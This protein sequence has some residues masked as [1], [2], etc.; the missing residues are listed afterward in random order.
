MRATQMLRDQHRAIG[1]LFDRVLREV[2]P[3]ERSR[4]IA[5]L[6][7]ELIAHMASEETVF[8]PAVEGMVDEAHLEAA[9][10]AH[11]EV[12]LQLR[13][14]LETSLKHGSPD[15]RVR[16]LRELVERHAEEEE[17]YVFDEVERRM[18][19]ADLALLGH[20]LSGSRPPIWIVVREGTRAFEKL[21]SLTRKSRVTLP[22]PAREGGKA[23]AARS[24]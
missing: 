10:A 13:R 5:E 15:A 11:A 14:V 4:A 24:G 3:S 1:A 9:R 17:R 7:E 21:A 20:E 16:M 8:Y 6:A 23:C 2:V 12:R 19:E 22:I 18:A